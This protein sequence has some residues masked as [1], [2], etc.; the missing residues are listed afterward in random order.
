MH[1]YIFHSEASTTDELTDSS[2]PEDCDRAEMFIL[3]K[4]IVAI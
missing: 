4:D 2:G 1:S 3:F